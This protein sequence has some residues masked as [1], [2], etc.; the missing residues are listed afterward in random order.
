M[1]NNADFFD[2]HQGA[3]LDNQISELTLDTDFTLVASCIFVDESE[4]AQKQKLKIQ[5]AHEHIAAEKK[6][7]SSIKQKFLKLIGSE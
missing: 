3:N 7:P 5:L 6:R 4:E 2:F 1:S